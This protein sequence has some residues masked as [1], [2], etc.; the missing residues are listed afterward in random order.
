MALVQSSRVILSARRRCFGNVIVQLTVI[1]DSVAV[2][3]GTLDSASPA[4]GLAIA[5]GEG[6]GGLAVDQNGLGVAAGRAI[7]LVCRSRYLAERQG[8]WLVDVTYSAW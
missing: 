7:E 4:Q 6:G 3:L 1:T 8:R 2:V 5:G